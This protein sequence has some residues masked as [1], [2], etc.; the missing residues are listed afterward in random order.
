M[1]LSEKR[2]APEEYRPERPPAGVRQN[3]EVKGNRPLDG[4]P[5]K[6]VVAARGKT[7][8]EPAAAS[9]KGKPRD[10]VAR[11][12]EAG[13]KYLVRRQGADGGWC[14]GEAQSAPL[15][16]LAFGRGGERANVAH[17]SLNAL[18][19]LRAGRG[20]G[21]GPY[22]KNVARAVSLVCS[23]VE[24]SDRTSPRVATVPGTVIQTKLGPYIDTYLALRFLAEVRGRMPDQAGEK[25]VAAA[26][27][28]LVAKVERGQRS[29][30]AWVKE[31]FTSP[32]AH[33][34]VNQGLHKA[35]QAGVS[36]ADPVLRRAQSSALE[37]CAW[38]LAVGKDAG[39]G[40]G[41]FSGAPA[42]EAEWEGVYALSLA[43]AAGYLGTIHASLDSRRRLK[44]LPDAEKR[45]RPAVA[46]IIKGLRD[47]GLVK[48][49][50]HSDHY[51]GGEEYLSF[52]FINELLAARGGKDWE[53]WKSR[54]TRRLLRQQH[55]DGSWSAEHC[56]CGG[57]F[58]TP[59]ALLA[60]L[61]DPANRRRPPEKT[62]AA[63]TSPARGQRR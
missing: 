42:D 58:C 34:L 36:V 12:I 9:A 37:S 6:E 56:M 1:T 45:S 20:S 3:G 63:P 28:R 16:A 13:L 4:P 18:A 50:D 14:E 61:A 30:G 31:A 17:T 22:S 19:L 5:A 32:L 21:L 47:P 46:R 8:K 52:L 33:A 10:V 11:R 26:L 57:N 48:Y 51:K 38:G 40:K 49:L 41:T 55:R 62:A 2:H 53:V 54:V 44:Q 7:R 27:T 39:S 15:L 59:A 43:S 25:Q 24:K 29:N 35:R 23:Q 60:L